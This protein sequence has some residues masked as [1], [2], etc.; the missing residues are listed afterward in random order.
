MKVTGKNDK[1]IITFDYNSRLVQLVKQLNGR[2]YLSHKKCWTLPLAGSMPSLKKLTG[3]GFDV[4]VDLVEAVMGDEREAKEVEALAVMSDIEFS[5][6]LGLYPYQKVGSAFLTRI[7]SGLLGDC[8]GSGKTLMVLAVIQ[9]TNAQRVLVFCP[10]SVKYQWQSEIEKF[11]GEKVVSQVIDGDKKKRIEQWRAPARVFI[12]NYELLLRD[13]NEMNREWDYV[14]ADEATRISNPQAKQSKLIKKLKA[15]HRIAMT[16]TPISNR[17]NEVWNVIDF[18]QPGVMGSYWSFLQKYCLK[19]QWGG[20]YGYQN[21]NELKQILKRYMIRRTKDEILPDL[22]EKTHIEIPF[23]LC[24]QERELYKKIKEE[25]LF[26]ID[27]TDINKLENPTTIQYTLT[28]MLRLQQLTASMELLGESQTSSK[29][30]IL[31]DL[32]P[33][34]VTDDVKVVI[35]T[36]FSKFA[37]IIEREL[38]EYKPLKITGEV[39]ER[40]PLIDKF[41]NEDENK[42]IIMTE[43]GAMGIN[44][45]YK[46]SVIIH[47]DLPYSIAKMEQ[48]EGRVHR[49]G[50]KNPVFIYHLIARKTID[51]HLKK[52]LVKK[53]ELKNELLDEPVKFTLNDVKQLLV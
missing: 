39:K 1:I 19:N 51:Q 27:K 4:D 3:W 44:L 16:G 17:A 5:T 10:S 41:N 24:E 50:Q 22:P 38:A 35:F 12:V 42:V 25:I 37:D 30:A 2:K 28:K 7:G 43:A 8:V 32:L 48:R 29:I 49:I 23:E 33:T 20:I 46:A 18:C 6:S 14:I 52:I 53:Q 13:F 26:E 11:L 36:K 45:Q 47:L 31:K 9:H 34:M 21:M 40:Q 15:K